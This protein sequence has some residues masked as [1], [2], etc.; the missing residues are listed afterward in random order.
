MNVVDP[1]PAD[2]VPSVELAGAWP[3]LE[4][5]LRRALG[6]SRHVAIASLDADGHP[7]L[8]P[9]G[10]L[11]LLP[12][13]GRAVYFERLAGALRR[14]VERDPRVAI[15]AVDGRLG[16]WLRSLIAGRFAEAPGLRLQAL[17]GERRAATD[18]E[19]ARWRRWVRRVR[20]TRG[21]DKLWGHLET[22]RELR[23]LAVEPLRL[24]G[25]DAS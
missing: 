21:H 1:G 10:S 19:V 8:T 14:N 2:A 9:I 18:E 13:V 23:I 20:W 11:M 3:A 4:R 12:E 15:L 6:S 17:A 5:L 22:V 16:F 7:H 25:M 24:G